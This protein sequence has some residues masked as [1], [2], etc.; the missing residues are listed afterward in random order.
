MT[1]KSFAKL[2]NDFILMSFIWS[3]NFKHL[4]S[5][6]GGQCDGNLS[7]LRRDLSAQ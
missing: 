5:F 7:E 3:M 2:I 1:L 6:H 4:F